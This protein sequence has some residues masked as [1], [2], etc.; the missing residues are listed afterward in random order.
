[1]CVFLASTFSLLAWEKHNYFACGSLVYSLADST[2]T[3][4]LR[5]SVFHMMWDVEENKWVCCHNK[6]CNLFSVHCVNQDHLVGLKRDVEY[7]VLIVIDISLCYRRCQHLFSVIC[8]LDVK[9]ALIYHVLNG[10]LLIFKVYK[11]RFWTLYS[12]FFHW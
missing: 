10:P 7:L 11:Y 12:C 2:P 9:S 1:M 5:N 6:G 3:T 4:Y 8:C